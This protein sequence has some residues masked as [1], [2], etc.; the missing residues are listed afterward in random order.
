MTGTVR[1][2]VPKLALLTAMRLSPGVVPGM[3]K[4]TWLKTLKN[5]ARNCMF[6]EPLKRKFRNT[7]MFQLWNDGPRR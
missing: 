5:S 4:F 3:S 7:P 2:I 1:V 6:I